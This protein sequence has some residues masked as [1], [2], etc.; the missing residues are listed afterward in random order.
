L[1]Q[2]TKEPVEATME[3]AQINNTR[4]FSFSFNYTLSG[5]PE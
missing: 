4:R 1:Q 2:D 3:S 5:D